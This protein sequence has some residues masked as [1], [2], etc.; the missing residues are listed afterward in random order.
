M[1]NITDLQWVLLD[2]YIYTYIHMDY[3]IVWVIL[4]WIILVIYGLYYFSGY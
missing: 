1:G 2:I 4:Y 3:I